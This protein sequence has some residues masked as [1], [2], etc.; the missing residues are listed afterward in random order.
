[1]DA[2]RYETAR[3]LGKTSVERLRQFPREPDILIYGFRCLAAL[4]IRA[5]L[6]TYHRMEVVG[7]EHIPAEGSFVLIANHSSHLDALCLMS[8]LPVRRIN[9]AFAA[10]ASDY[11][12]TSAPRVVVAAV[13]A[14]ALPF[15]RQAHCCQ[16]L[17]LCRELL[18]SPGNV[19]ILFPEG[20]RTTSGNIGTFKPGIGVLL[21][22][23]EVP[24]LPCH[25]AGAFE[26]CPRGSLLPRPVH[27]R[28]MIGGSRRY[29]SLRPGKPSALQICAELQQAVVD[30]G[31]IN[32]QGPAGRR[33]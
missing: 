24:V 6:H 19:L 27:L 13:V 26:A 18:A 16:S 11:F 17:A 14:N 1:M 4:T 25:I 9:Q 20:T 32:T 3:D 31:V 28:L 8:A 10:A 2:W 12:F 21:A 7:R 5:W 22:G 30:L 23:T 15:Y 29:S 33:D